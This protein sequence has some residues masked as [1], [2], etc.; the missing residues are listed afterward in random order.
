MVPGYIV[1]G[2]SKNIQLV[3]ELVSQRALKITMELNN[4]IKQKKKL[5]SR[6]RNLLTK[7]R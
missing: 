5:Y 3:H 6:C 4:N 2:G 7:N 1:D